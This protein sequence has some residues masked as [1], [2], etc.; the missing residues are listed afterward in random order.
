LTCLLGFNSQAELNR[1][2][3]VTK[4]HTWCMTCKRPFRSQE[5]RDKH[6]RLTTGNW[7]NG[8]ECRY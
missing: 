5:E 7:T 2:L 4:K 8:H 1:H 6:W 3:K